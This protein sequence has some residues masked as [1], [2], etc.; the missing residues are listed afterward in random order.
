MLFRSHEDELDYSDDELTEAEIRYIEIKAIADIMRETQYLKGQTLYDFFMSYKH[1]KDDRSPLYPLVAA[2]NDGQVAMTK[3]AHYYDVIRY[4]AVF[5]DEE[6][7][8]EELETMEETYLEEPF[9]VYTGVDRSIYRGTFALT[10][11]ADRADAYSEIDLM[12]TFLGSSERAEALNVTIVTG[13][14]SAFFFTLG[15]MS[16]YFDVSDFNIITSKAAANNVGNATAYM[17]GGEPLTYNSLIDSIYNTHHAANSSLSMMDKVAALKGDMAA[18]ELSAYETSWVNECATKVARE[19]ANLAPAGAPVTMSTAAFFVLGGALMIYSAFNIIS[20]VYNYYNPEYDDIPI[21]M[22]DLIETVDGD[23]YIKYDV[24]YEAET[25]EDGK[26]TAGDLNAFE[27]L[28]WNA[29]YYTKSY[30]AGKPLLADEFVVSN[31]SNQPKDNYAAV[32]AFGDTVCFDLNRHTF[33]DDTSIYLSIKQSKNNKYAVEGVPEVVGSMFGAG[34]LALAGGI[35]AIAGI[36]G[37]LAAQ[38]I[39]KKKKSNNDESDSL[40]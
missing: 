1:S 24:V 30:E 22:V 6:V 5:V 35:G 26:Y 7:I 31:S 33:D 12:D 20:T 11:A 25:R 28:R 18:G 15:G 14:L 17:S 2:L 16:R 37:T 39:A 34:F 38:G 19:Q 9:N 36:G 3:V 13:M 23:R 29:L 40:E 21:A 10:T 27:G 4:S 8:N 32:H